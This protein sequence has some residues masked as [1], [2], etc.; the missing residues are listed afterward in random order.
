MCVELLLVFP[1]YPL[2]VCSIDSDNLISFLVLVSLSL[3]FDQSF[4]RLVN[5]LIFSKNQIFVSFSVI[6]LVSISLR[7]SLLSFV[8][9]FLFF[10]SWGESLDYWY[11]T[12]LFYCMHLDHT[13]HCWFWFR[14]VLQ[15]SMCCDFIFIQFHVLFIF[16]LRLPLGP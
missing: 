4:F 3:F 12:S 9:I 8:L 10:G 7:S 2:D 15:I 6:F 11:K 13:L 1:Y 16:I 14:C 5:L